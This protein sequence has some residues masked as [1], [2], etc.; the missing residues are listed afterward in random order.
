MGV[1]DDYDIRKVERAVECDD[2]QN[3]HTH[4]HIL[5]HRT[6]RRRSRRQCNQCT[7]NTDFG[8]CLT[9]LAQATVLCR[10]S[11]RVVCTSRTGVVS[12]IEACFEYIVRMEACVQLLC[13]RGAW[14]SRVYV[15]SQKL[16][17]RHVRS[18]GV[19]FIL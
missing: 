13:N 16:F 10:D 17:A 7:V 12:T 18:H 9:W 5:V 4:I 11:R 1:R 8:L 15:L 6:P 2:T 14:H 3:I 19:V